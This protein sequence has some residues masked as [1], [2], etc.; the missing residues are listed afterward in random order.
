MALAGQIKWPTKKHVEA[1]LVK[2]LGQPLGIF[3]ILNSSGET[4][5]AAVFDQLLPPLKQE[6][7]S[8][9]PE[10][11]EEAGKNQFEPSS[12][13]EIQKALTCIPRRRS[14]QTDIDN[15]GPGSYSNY[16]NALWGSIKAAE[17]VGH[18]REEVIQLWKEH[19][20]SSECDWDVEQVANSGGDQIEADSFWWLANEHGYKAQPK[21]AKNEQ[22]ESLTPA[23]KLLRLEECAKDLK[24]SKAPY[25]RRLPGIRSLA[26]DIG[27]SMRDQELA[28]M[29]NCAGK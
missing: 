26:S 14:G 10:G 29:L 7:S 17:A 3:S 23:E 11:F 24:I 9:I 13:E 2:E 18:T 6:P 28:N 21:E 12:W 5:T 20:P 19:S 16:R 15:C 4:H 22:Q 8:F 1:G 27:I 25:H